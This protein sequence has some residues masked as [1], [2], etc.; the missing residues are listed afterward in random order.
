M[1]GRTVSHYRILEKLGEGGMGVVYKADDLKLHR[2]VALKFLAPR[3]LESEQ[4]RERFVREARAAAGLDHP[5]VCT[6]YEID[7]ADG[8]FFIAMA[9][10]DGVT[11][12]ER[13]ES[14]ALPVEDA[15]SLATQVAQG[16]L[17]AHERGIVHRDVKGGNI[18]LGTDGRAKLVDFGLAR[19]SEIDPGGETA[20]L[21]GTPAWM[22]PEQLRGEPLDAR[23]DIWSLGVVLYEMLAGKPPFTGRHPGQ[24]VYSVLHEDPAPL[25]PG[26]PDIP[27]ELD[28]IVGRALAKRREDRYADAGELLSDLESFSAGATSGLPRRT[29]EDTQARRSIAVLAFADMSPERDQEYFC[30]GLAEEIIGCLTHV[31]GLRVASRTSSFAFKGRPG[32]VRAIGR[33]LGVETVLEGSVRK[34]DSRLRITCQLIDVSG[35]YHLWSDQF[36]RELCDI[37]AIQEEIAQSVA[38]ALEVELSEREA[39]ALECCETSDVQAYEF[40][41]RGRQF[42]YRSKRKDIEHA[43]EMFSRAVAQDP[44]Y[45]RAHAGLADCHSYLYMYFGGAAD[46]L[47]RAGEASAA[48][49][50]LDPGL[51]EAHAARGLALSHAQRY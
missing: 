29:G 13:L 50:E 22:S 23:T 1:I 37:F 47:R 5:S 35:G 30:D 8:R 44:S 3:A 7:E 27:P 49:L 18:M 28:G 45:A 46:D 51:A 48:A 10:V 43:I 31:T 9:Y 24:V 25:A 2:T 26:N 14:G 41:L 11:V 32:D 40:Y 42:F 38:R 21:E 4:E 36:D 20:V 16:L 15:V 17:A 33:E 19:A 12:K 6:V 34:A 39:R